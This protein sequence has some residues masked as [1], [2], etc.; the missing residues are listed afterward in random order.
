MRRR[1]ELTDAQWARLA[2]LLPPRKPG[3]PRKD[4]RLV[5][6]G[7]LWKLA[8]GAP[9]RDLPERYGPWQSVYTRFRR[10]TRAGVWDGIFE[11][12]QQ[13]ADAAGELDW[14][15]HFVDGTVIRA[16]Q[17]AAGAKESDPEAEAL[18][19][20]QGGWSTKVHLR[21]EGHGKPMTLV[22]TPGQRHEAT[23]FE[24]L[25]E[26]GAIRR[27]GR[28]RPRRRPGRVVG[29][30]G[31][32]GRARR[33]YCRRRGIRYTIPRLRTERRGGRFDRAAYR[34]RNRVERLI[35]R[36]KQFRSL[37]TRYDKRATSYRA[38]WLLAMIMLWIAHAH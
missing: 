23:A 25:L 31:Y 14:A 35:A 28:G 36:C 4:D 12:V 32:T 17:H 29:D 10:W 27:P 30:R 38:L 2:P 9:W 20:S 24:Q 34:L 3:K 11:A 26:Q 5:I 1:H 37:A 21:A 15:V 7:I 8:T 6:D 22:L 19:R 13:Q 33:A 18:G 16:H